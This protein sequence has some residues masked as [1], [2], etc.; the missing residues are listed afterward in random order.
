MLRRASTDD[1]R[2]TDPDMPADVL[3]TLA[4]TRLVTLGPAAGGGRLITVTP[5]GYKSLAAS[6]GTDYRTTLAKL[7]DRAPV[8]LDELMTLDLIRVADVR[9]ILGVSHRTANL[10]VEKGLLPHFEVH[11]RSHRVPYAAVVQ[12]LAERLVL[13]RTTTCSCPCTCNAA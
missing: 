1:V 3:R 9:K 4:D 11:K 2:D 8:S 6:L 13:P 10:L 5:E 7:R 12:Y